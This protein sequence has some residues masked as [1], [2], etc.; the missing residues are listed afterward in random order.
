[1]Y[2][3]RK[4]PRIFAIQV[5]C[6]IRTCQPLL[7]HC[8]KRQTGRDKPVE[9]RPRPNLRSPRLLLVRQENCEA[10]GERRCAKGPDDAVARVVRE[11]TH[12]VTTM[13]AK[14]SVE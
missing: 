3:K 8:R 5:S 7:W 6:E 2:L 11:E 10:F 13:S 9:E 1:M 14:L 4:K 12:Y